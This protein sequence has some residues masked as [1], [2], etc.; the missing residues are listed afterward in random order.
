MKDCFYELRKAYFDRLN[1]IIVNGTKIPFYDIVPTTAD[2]PYIYVLDCTTNE[3]GDKTDYGQEVTITINIV[4]K[5]D[6]SKG[7]HKE[8]DNIASEVIRLIRTR[9]SGYLTMTNHYIIVTT[10]DNSVSLTEQTEKGKLVTRSV[11]FRHTIS[12]K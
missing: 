3:E 8:V 2:E 7:G 1:N 9:S 11:R 6:N 4:Q 12:E 5:Y 10:L